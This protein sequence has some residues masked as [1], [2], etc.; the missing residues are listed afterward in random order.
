MNFKGGFT[1]GHLQ[2]LGTCKQKC[3]SCL[4][5]QGKSLAHCRCLATQDRV[6]WVSHCTWKKKVK[7]PLDSF[8]GKIYMNWIFCLCFILRTI[9]SAQQEIC[10]LM[11]ASPMICCWIFLPTCK[12][13][14][15]C[16]HPSLAPRLCGLNPGL[17][18][19]VRSLNQAELTALTSLWF[20]FQLTTEQNHQV[21]HSG[22]IDELD[23]TPGQGSSQ[24]EQ[25]RGGSSSGFWRGWMAIPSNLSDC[26]HRPPT[27]QMLISFSTQRGCK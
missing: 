3:C 14:Y 20:L 12:V 1:W 21:W 7:L 18:L 15:I 8:S 27:D 13:I 26:L 11:N 22:A 23:T 17:S 2:C 10:F 16:W 4:V 6:A 19:S 24:S 25:K 5:L 9:L